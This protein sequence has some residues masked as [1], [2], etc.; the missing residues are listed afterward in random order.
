MDSI[1]EVAKQFQNIKKR[2]TEDTLKIDGRTFQIRKFDPLLGNY[3]VM[4]L[5]MNVIPFGLGDT[6]SEKVPGFSSVAN[7]ANTGKVMDKATFL[8]LQ[9]D[10][11]SHAVEILPGD[12][13]PVVRE[14]GTYGIMNFTQKICIELLIAILAFNFSDFFG[15]EGS[16]NGDDS[17]Q[18]SNSANMKTSAQGFTYL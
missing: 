14:N 2:V 7:K 13:A 5:F 18:D 1:K 6:L 17:V 8:D 10:I 11:L 4:Q 15:E 16:S 12:K 9:R 3:I